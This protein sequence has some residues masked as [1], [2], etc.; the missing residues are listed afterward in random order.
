MMDPNALAENVPLSEL[1]ASPKAAKI[2][3]ISDLISALDKVCEHTPVHAC[4]DAFGSVLARSELPPSEWLRFALYD[5]NKLY[6]RNLVHRNESYA[7]LI[8]RWNPDKESPIHDH[9]CDGCWLKVLE[10]N[11]EETIYTKDDS[12]DIISEVSHNR[13][14]QGSLTFMHDNIGIHKIANPSRDEPA[15]SLHLYS[16]P[17]KACKVWSRTLQASQYITPKVC[18]YSVGGVRVLDGL[19]PGAAPVEDSTS[20][21]WGREEGKAHE[22]TKSNESK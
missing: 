11:I 3:T 10:G 13:Y 16:P 14:E 1:A 15:I 6:T 22:E 8:L 18:Y 19:S 9:P 7:L 4:Q 5:E 21:S 17:F 20:L 12:S 2:D